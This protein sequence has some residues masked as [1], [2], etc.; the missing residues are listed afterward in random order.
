MLGNTT[1]TEKKPKAPKPPKK[2]YCQY[3]IS[4]DKKPPKDKAAFLYWWYDCLKTSY[5]QYLLKKIN[6]EFVKR[7]FSDWEYK[8]IP[9]MWNAVKDIMAKSTYLKIREFAQQNG[10]PLHKAYKHFGFNYT[11]ERHREDKEADFILL[12]LRK[13]EAKLEES[14]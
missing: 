5:I 8:Y 11:T 7:E 10:I 4:N 3:E 6:P 14:L 13:F 2:L 9:A 1:A 12:R